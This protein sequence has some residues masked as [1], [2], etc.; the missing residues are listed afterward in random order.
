MAGEKMQVLADYLESKNLF[1]CN[2]FDYFMDDADLTPRN[3]NIGKGCLEITAFEYAASFHIERF[4]HDAEL[5]AA[6]IN[7]WLMDNDCNRDNFKLAPPRLTVMPL[8]ERDASVVN[9]EFQID[10]VEIITMKKDKNGLIDYQGKSYSIAP[11]V[12]N[13]AETLSTEGETA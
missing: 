12:I 8:N 3:K 10:F 5:L 6:V 11:P 7:T 1:D 13:T 2:T 4:T 9:I